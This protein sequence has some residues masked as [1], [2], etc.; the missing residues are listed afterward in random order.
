MAEFSLKDQLFN[1]KKVRQLASELQAAMPTFPSDSFIEDICCRLPELEL[2]ERLHWI[3]T[4]LSTYLPSN[5]KEAVS[6]ILAALP[7]PCDPAKKDD[8]FGEF[9]Y[10]PYNQ[11]IA[12]H[13]CT[14]A[15][16][17]L[18][19]QT[20]EKTTTRF[21]AEDAIRVF[22]N[23]FPKKTLEYLQRWTTHPH[24]HV[25]RLVSEGTRPALPWAK[26]IY[27]QS[28]EFLA[29][30]D[31]LYYD[32]T[33][34]VTR[35]VANHLNDVSKFNPDAVLH[36]LRI[37]QE[38]Q[39]QDKREFEYI[40]RHA[41][42]TLVKQGH[43]DTLSYLGYSKN[44]N[45]DIRLILPS[46]QVHIGDTLS[47]SIQINAHEPCRLLIDFVIYFKSK[48]TKASEKVFK[49]RTLSLNKGEH[50]VIKKNYHFKANMTTRPLY[51]G[52]HYIQLQVN[53]ARLR[54]HRFFLV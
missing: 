8:D 20:L 12:E 1:E 51:P 26:K 13:G 18:S 21:S 40:K 52:H 33:R 5:F 4:T 27:Y 37:W 38:D 43:P 50:I 3:A 48:T 53:G 28:S 23:R 42:R 7:A 35:S 16:V 46:Q 30:L 22:I 45:T 39:K 19:L 34:F 29:L 49:L 36:K 9:I 41:L 32:P 15:F 44:P 47:F 6:I 24:Y 17:D 11:F 10:A 2:K 14:E 25:R 31:I 54:K